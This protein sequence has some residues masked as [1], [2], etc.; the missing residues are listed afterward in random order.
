[1]ARYIIEFMFCS[2]LFVAL[3]KLLIKGRV[4]HHQARIYLVSALILSV[5]IPVLELPL[6]PAQ[7]VYFE[8]PI[9]N[10]DVQSLSSSTVVGEIAPA[11]QSASRVDWRDIL[12]MVAWAVYIFVFTLNIARFVY[13][14]WV[15]RSLRL[16]A[17]LA[18]YEDYI[19]A[20]SERISEPFSFWRTIFM[21]IRYA[22]RDR[23]QIIIHEL[24]HIRHHHTAERLAVELLR[25]VFWF[26]PF[27]W[28]V[29]HYLVEVQEWEAD[30]DVLSRGYDVYEYRQLIFRQLF[31]YNTDITCGLNSQLTKNRFLM[32][33]N[34]KK[35]KLSFMRFGV[36]IPM[37]GAM[38]LAF[39]AVR[40]EAETTAPNVNNEQASALHQ[41]GN[42]V[43]ISADGT[44]SYKGKV[45]T[46][47]EL[48]QQLA[49][50]RSEIDILTISA[51]SEA[52]VGVLD[53]V[54]LA[55]RNSGVLRVNISSSAGKG[56][57]MVLPP[58]AGD[59]NA[60]VKS[61]F[62]T[63]TKVTKTDFNELRVAKNNLLCVGVNSLG[64]I[65]TTRPDGKD[66]LVELDE[67]KDIVKQFVDNTESVNGELKLKN[68]HYSSF[69][70]TNIEKGTGVVR[71]PASNGIVSILTTR[72]L[73]VEN[74]LSVQ[75]TIREAYAEL[76]EELAQRS[77][78]QSYE[79]LSDEDRTYIT[80]AIPIKVSTAE[81]DIK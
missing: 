13:R 20:V 3:Y 72:D 64:K 48:E 52:R 46:L 32:M 5:V 1:M 50:D 26:N 61:T 81:P 59:P 37:V 27:V 35:G 42:P 76:R 71:Y 29:G 34:F 30:S 45:V 31:G 58:P 21:G 60:P 68:P 10:T 8:L 55:A 57:Y 75:T 70:W 51:D 36:A 80:R 19:L 44:I 74:Y 7:T 67:L 63:V 28:L 54:K 38:I 73:S 15:I 2:G 14:L 22:G 24:S 23:E 69:I 41:I 79:S 56:V 17:Q 12:S 11:V 78:K 16:N 49:A 9:I 33:T 4:A 62:T 40:A 65:M 43:L 53:D 18:V 66:G 6:Y 25:C 39:G 77:F 47:Q